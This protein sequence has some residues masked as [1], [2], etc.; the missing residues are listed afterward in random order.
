MSS[1]LVNDCSCNGG[2]IPTVVQCK[3]CVTGGIS[4]TFNYPR[5]IATNQRVI[6]NQVRAA[7]SQYVSSLAALNVRGTLIGNNNNN[8]VSAYSYVN[9]NQ[10][11]DRA[12]PA[13]TQRYVPSRGNSTKTSLTRCRPG[14][15]CPGGGSVSS[16][17]VDVKH[18]SYDRYLARKKA[19]AIRQKPKVSTESTEAERAYYTQYSLVQDSACNC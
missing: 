11:S 6:Q 7:A 12:Q 4:D 17:G 14:A 1:F 10:S 2:T 19:G 5:W 13:V 3:T 9:W 8:P 16:A 15:A 18:N